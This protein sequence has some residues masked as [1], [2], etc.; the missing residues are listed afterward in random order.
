MLLSLKISID[1]TYFYQYSMPN[2][3]NPQLIWVAN[4]LAHTNAKECRRT[5]D[6]LDVNTVILNFSVKPMDFISHV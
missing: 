6:N 2:I 3:E 4:S 1:D 5:L